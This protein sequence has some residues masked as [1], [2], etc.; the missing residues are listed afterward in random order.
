MTWSGDYCVPRDS[1]ADTSSPLSAEPPAGRMPSSRI[2]FP[3]PLDPTFGEFQR[4]QRDR[5][6]TL[7]FQCRLPPKALFC[8][9]YRGNTGNHVP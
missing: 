7:Y 6:Q 8:C 2:N 5:P 9:N 3:W 1:H 4:Q